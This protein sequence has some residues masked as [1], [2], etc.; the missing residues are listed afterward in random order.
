[1]T[2]GAIDLGEGSVALAPP[3]L[4]ARFG[5]FLAV[6]G[7]TLALLPLAWLAP[8]LV[9]TDDAELAAGFFTF[10]VA[11]VLN[12]PHFSVTYLLFYDDVRRR[13]FGDAFGRAQRIRYLVAGF[14]VPALL[15]GWAAVA[16]ARH[17]A[18]LLG[19]EIQLM[20][21][22]V[23]WHYVKQGFGVLSTLA[24]RRGRKIRPRERLALLFHCYA[25]WGFAWANPAT[26]AGDFE[27][28]GV[29][30]RS[31]A[32]PRWLELVTGSVLAA[33]VLVLAWA[34]VVE[35]RRAEAR[36]PL[37]PFVVFLISVWVWSVFSAV[38]PIVRYFVPA[39]HS[40][41]YL[42]F[43]GLLRRAELRESAGAFSPP[44]TSRLVLFALSALGLGFVLF[45][46]VPGILDA[47]LF[48]RRRA[49][50]DLGPTPFFAAFFV[51]VNLH[52]YVMDAVIWRREN[53]KMQLLARKR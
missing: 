17:S 45:H 39:L 5:E 4:A 29:V 3:G 11:F 1:M 26:P 6:G 38:N 14:V 13:A 53:P 43:V 42:Y 20:F 31:V 49:P 50:D 25:A 52:H 21:L 10:H 9:G 27:E 46:G 34:L 18:R 12:D 7:A 15:V 51:V 35:R 19:F 40:L 33:S 36:M 37:G 23:G 47:T 30:F 22:L 44:L 41:Q 48:G 16:V 2:T 28:K 32:H 24:A 8:K